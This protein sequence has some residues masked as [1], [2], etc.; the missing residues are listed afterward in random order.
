MR[1][2]VGARGAPL[3]AREDS[4]RRQERQ[5]WEASP[6]ALKAL[7][8]AL[9][10][11]MSCFYYVPSRSWAWNRTAEESAHFSGSMCIGA[12]DRFSCV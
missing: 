6:M 2:E 4:V 10:V 1:L 11:A 5:I 3:S 12:K 7:G 9:N 8:A